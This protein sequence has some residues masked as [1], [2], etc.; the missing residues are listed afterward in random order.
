MCSSDL[1]QPWFT[2]AVLAQGEG[3]VHRT[4]Q[5]RPVSIYYLLARNSAEERMFR[6]AEEKRDVAESIVS[7]R[8]NHGINGEDLQ[9]L[10]FVENESPQKNIVSFARTF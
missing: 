7:S 3:R 9:T 2:Y 8:V 4:G 10:L 1:L 5:T 6:R